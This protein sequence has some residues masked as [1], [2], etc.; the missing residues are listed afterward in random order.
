[1]EQTNSPITRSNPSPIIVIIF[2]LY[3][4]IPLAIGV[5]ETLLKASA[6]FK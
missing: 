4:G 3:V 2:W 1:M 5:W 6:L